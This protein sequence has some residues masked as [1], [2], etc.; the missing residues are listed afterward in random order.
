MFDADDRVLLVRFEWPN[1]SMWA[2]PGGGIEPDETPS[3]AA[4]RE[5]VEE[6]GLSHGPLVGPIWLRTA[7]FDRMPGYDGQFEHYFT[8]RVTS[9]ALAPTM[10]VEELRAEFLAGAA[11]WSIADMLTSTE[12]FAPK[13]LAPLLERLAADGAPDEPLEIGN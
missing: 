12:R 2:L 3:E 5:V 4:R 10:S 11:W 9:T 7:I 1:G 8:A 6:T 13:A